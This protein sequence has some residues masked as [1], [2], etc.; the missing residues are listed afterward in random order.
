MVSAIIPQ[1]TTDIMITLGLADINKEG[2]LVDWHATPER[3]KDVSASTGAG[4]LLAHHDRHTVRQAL[5]AVSLL[6]SATGG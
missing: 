1:L 4:C 3:F 6:N 2:I 5:P